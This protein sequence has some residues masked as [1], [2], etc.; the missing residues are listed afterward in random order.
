MGIKFL[1]INSDTNQKIFS[2]YFYKKSIY[3]ENYK[4]LHEGIQKYL[5]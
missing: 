2:N 4:S 3:E 5:N 1:I